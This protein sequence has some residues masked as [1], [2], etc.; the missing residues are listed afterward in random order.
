MKWQSMC[1]N[2]PPINVSCLVNDISNYDYGYNVARF[3]GCHWW[4]TEDSSDYT[5]QDVTHFCV[6]EPVGETA[7]E[8][9]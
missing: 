4:Y 8:D 3:D 6:I 9:G 2:I 5:A 1:D 7:C